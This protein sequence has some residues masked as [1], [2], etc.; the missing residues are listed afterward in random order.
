MAATTLFHAANS[1]QLVNARSE[2]PASTHHRPPVP[3]L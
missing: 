2:C 3:D 1:C